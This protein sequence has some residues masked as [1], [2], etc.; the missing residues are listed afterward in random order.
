M[1]GMLVALMLLSWIFGRTRGLIGGLAGGIR[2]G[3]RGRRHDRRD[4]QR[5]T[6]CSVQPRTTRLGRCAG[7]GRRRCPRAGRAVR[8]RLRRGGLG[9]RRASCRNDRV[10]RRPVRVCTPVGCPRRRCWRHR[11][12]RE[13]A[14]GSLG[15]LN[16]VTAPSPELGPPW[17]GGR[18]SPPSQE[19]RSASESRRAVSH[20]LVDGPKVAEVLGQTGCSD[21]SHVPTVPSGAAVGVV[22]RG[23]ASTVRTCGA[24]SRRSAG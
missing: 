8:D 16:L 2:R 13:M 11:A 18:W 3:P 23:L 10:R 14:R 4:E 12:H 20:G 15:P 5:R 7:S 24:R 21:R 22:R 9:N 17:R 19:S 6:G 1:I